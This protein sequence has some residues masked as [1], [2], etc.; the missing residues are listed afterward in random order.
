MGGSSSQRRTNPAISPINAFSVEELY[1]PQFSDTF[2]ENT[3]YW[4]EPNP[5]VS[6]VEQVATSPPKKKKPARARQKRIIQSDDAPRQIAWTIEEEIA[7]AKG[8]VAI[9]KNNKHG[10]ARKE[11]D[12]WCETVRPAVIRFCEV[13]SNVMRMAHEMEPPTKITLTGQ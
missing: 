11:D 7:L 3:D 2:Q 8:W 4:Q 1:S 10:N 6:P 13:Y 5:H 12:F 9:S